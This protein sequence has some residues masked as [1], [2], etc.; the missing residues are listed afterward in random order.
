MEHRPFQSIT[1]GQH[2]RSPMYNGTPS[3]PSMHKS[4][5]RK[6]SKTR[7]ARRLHA[8]RMGLPVG[9]D[10]RP[11]ALG[12]PDDASRLRDP[13]RHRPPARRGAR[14]GTLSSSWTPPCPRRGELEEKMS[15][16]SHRAGFRYR[17]PSGR[18]RKP[19][20][21][22]LRQ[23]PNPA[24]H[25]RVFHTHFAIYASTST[26]PGAVRI[27]VPNFAKDR[28]VE[29]RA[30]VHAADGPGD[31]GIAVGIATIE[32]V[33]V[34]QEDRDLHGLGRSLVHSRIFLAQYM[35]GGSHAS[36]RSAPFWR[37]AAFQS[38]SCVFISQTRRGR[39]DIPSRLRAEGSI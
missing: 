19:R 25:G 36:F 22:N 29:P 8:A 3:R 21:R 1:L 20:I 15:A 13:P 33:A 38:A 17:R 14:P 9:R 35:R 12:H 37:C 4:G 24:F 11:W 27:H 34:V 28:T 7:P 23:M 32:L 10:P 5:N 39:S 26:C 6:Y 2:H 30:V 18:R 31:A 16:S